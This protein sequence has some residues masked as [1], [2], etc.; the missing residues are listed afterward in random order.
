MKRYFL[1][2]SSFIAWKGKYWSTDEYSLIEP[3]MFQ[4]E[5]YDDALGYQWQKTQFQTILG[6]IV[7]DEK[8]YRLR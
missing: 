7:L 3:S 1:S 6:E 4:E 2:L 8:V 5:Y